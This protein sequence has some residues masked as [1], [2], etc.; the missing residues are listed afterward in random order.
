MALLINERNP[1]LALAQNIRYENGSTLDS[2][3]LS[4]SQADNNKYDQTQLKHKLKLEH[5]FYDQE[6]TTKVSFG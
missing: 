5:S 2:S 6:W 3:H 4:G 1:K